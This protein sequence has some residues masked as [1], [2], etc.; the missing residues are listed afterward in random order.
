V[1]LGGDKG[2][3]EH[4]AIGNPE[5]R[6]YLGTPGGKFFTIYRTRDGA[7]MKKLFALLYW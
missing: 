1:R 2:G 3:I 4:H 7:A 6:G 5:Y